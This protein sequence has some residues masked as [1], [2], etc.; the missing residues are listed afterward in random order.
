MGEL[1]RADLVAPDGFLYTNGNDVYAS[2]IWLGEGMNP[3]SFHLISKEEY[4][5]IMAELEDTL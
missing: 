3:S 2:K 4:E 1:S 5:K